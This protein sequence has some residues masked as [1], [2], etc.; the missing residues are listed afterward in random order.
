MK[1][2][3]LNPLF[4]PYDGEVYKFYGGIEPWAEGLANYW[5]DMNHEVKFFCGYG[6]T[7]W[8]DDI[9]VFSADHPPS[10]RDTYRDDELPLFKLYEKE[11]LDCDVIFDQTHFL[12]SYKEKYIDGWDN[13]IFST[14]HHSP[15]NVTSLPPVD[16]D[17]IVSIS[18]WQAS[19]FKEKFGMNFKVIYSG[20]RKE[21]MPEHAF[22]KEHDL[23][24][25][26]ARFS[27]IKAPHIIMDMADK[28][29]ECRFVLLGDCIFTNEP[30]YTF[31]LQREASKRINVMFIPN[32]D[33]NTKIEYLQRACGL[34]HPSIIDE[35]GSIN[36][37]EA[38]FYGTPVYT[39]KRG[40]FPE[41]VKNNRNG[42]LIP[43]DDFNPTSEEILNFIDSFENFRTK[44][45]NEDKIK[46]EVLYLDR[47]AKKYID[48]FRRFV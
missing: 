42:M 26:L 9:Q 47:T 46:K 39:W 3:I 43:R 14:W 13:T 7:Q 38:N 19:K 21:I 18:K 29:P 22:P 31:M 30:Y 36:F 20:I 17:K 2:A 16:R 44:S 32:A 12:P 34:I 4:F 33:Y 41:I 37:C 10:Y 5:A 27:T 6:S 11:I 8:R 35:P 25:F 15:F 48:Y 24:I 23:Y 40:A 45:W 1:I 28:Y